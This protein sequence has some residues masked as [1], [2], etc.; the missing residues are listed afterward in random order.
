MIDSI[1]R[2]YQYRSFDYSI[3][4][5]IV[6]WKKLGVI[7]SPWQ[8]TVK[9][10]QIFWMIDQYYHFSGYWWIDGHRSE[11]DFMI[12]CR[13]YRYK[14]KY[15]PMDRQ[16]RWK[17]DQKVSIDTIVLIQRSITDC[18]HLWLR[19]TSYIKINNNNNHNLLFS[20]D[21]KRFYNIYRNDL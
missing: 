20:P 14:K 18:A 1:G 15:L 21:R 9:I 2:Y 17:W 16:Q 10:R 7:S 8:K 3:K 19:A 6:F 13:Y 11:K 4:I 5:K 12:N